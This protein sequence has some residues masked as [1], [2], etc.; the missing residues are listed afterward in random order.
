[1]ENIHAALGHQYSSASGFLAFRESQP[2]LE[3]F[4]RLVRD[5]P[6]LRPQVIII[7]CGTR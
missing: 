4:N 3:A 7:N 2:C 6:E 1:M 5:R